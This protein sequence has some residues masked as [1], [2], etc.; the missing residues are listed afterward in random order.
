[1]GEDKIFL[2]LKNQLS[3]LERLRHTVA[4]FGQRHRLPARLLFE[5]NLALE[6]I[7]VNII[8]YGFEDE[9]DA[10][11]WV[12][13]CLAQGELRAEVQD[14][15]KAFNPLEMPPPDTEQP[16]EQR[17]VGGLGLHLVRTLMDEVVYQRQDNRNIL[18]LKKKVR[19]S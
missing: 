9:Q 14:N 7:V 4:E 6:E 18:T 5:T 12:G 10:D 11:I 19:E 13:L 17:S 3:E 8:S 15:G 1:M 2:A 16:L